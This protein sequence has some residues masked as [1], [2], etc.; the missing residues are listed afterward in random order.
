M[1]KRNLTG[2]VA[3]IAVL[4]AA[5]MIF[6][7]PAF[8]ADTSATVSANKTQVSRGEEVTFTVNVKA[9]GAQSLLVNILVDGEQIQ[10]SDFELVTADLDSD[11]FAVSVQIMTSFDP[12]TNSAVYLFNNAEDIDGTAL[13]FTL[14]AKTDAAL[15]SKSVGAYVSTD[16]GVFNNVTPAQ[17]KVVCAA[18]AHDWSDAD[19]LNAKTCSICNATEGTALGHKWKSATCQAPK[20]CDR[21]H[22]TDGAVGDHKFIKGNYSPEY[23]KS[24][25][26]CDNRE[27]YYKSCQ[28]CGIKGGESDVYEYGSALG[29]TGGTATCDSG[30]ICTRCNNEYDSPAHTYIE[31]VEDRYLVSVATCISKA[32]YNKS[33]QYCDDVSNDTFEFGELASHTPS[34]EWSSD[35]D[36]H[37]KGC[38]QEECVI[39]SD[40]GAHDWDDGV[41]TE[42]ATENKEGKKTY[43]C[44]VCSNTKVESIDKLTPSGGGDKE[45]D[46]EDN[47]ENNNDKKGVSHHG[48]TA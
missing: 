1:K 46:K 10:A 32:V 3:I 34:D 24:A 21:C 22:L 17:V 28:Y 47:K 2:I 48:P 30:P 27:K 43:T 40:V 23:L 12:N 8:A 44:S 26:D 14:K 13:T 9:S 42:A 16:I 11:L 19:C 4:V 31:K 45:D 18:N 20:T 38:S 5:F 7:V 37:W 15:E 39:R 35:D 36:N 25:A 41:V 29:H 33:C 6:A